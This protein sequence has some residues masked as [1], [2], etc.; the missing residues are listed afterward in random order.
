MAAIMRRKY[1]ENGNARPVEK[2]AE[3]ASG[4]PPTNETVRAN[5]VGTDPIRILRLPEV[6]HITGLKRAMIYRLQQ[7]DSFPQ[8]VRITDHAV[9]WV[10][11]EVQAWLK[12]RVVARRSHAGNE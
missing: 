8:S 7:M 3:A 6:C 1:K 2:T 4:L 12:Q 10:D 11:S 9:G 5:E